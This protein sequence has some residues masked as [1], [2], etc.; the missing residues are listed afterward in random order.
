MPLKNFSFVVPD[1]VAGMAYPRSA[2][3]LEELVRMGFGALV[4]LADPPP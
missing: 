1:E 4:S 2:W 3:E